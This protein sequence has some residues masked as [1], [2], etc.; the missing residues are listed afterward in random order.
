MEG[1][2]PPIV[3]R[4]AEHVECPVTRV[5][6][7]YPLHT[8]SPAA[9]SPA[10]GLFHLKMKC[11]NTAYFLRFAGFISI[12]CKNAGYFGG[13]LFSGKISCIFASYLPET[14]FFKKISCNFALQYR[15][16]MMSAHCRRLLRHRDGSHGIGSTVARTAQSFAELRRFD[17]CPYDMV[18]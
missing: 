4:A 14:P 18:V 2:T 11:K 8:R 5:M 1:R 9:R 10:F 16:R 12:W 6:P 3:V 15:L 17:A 13:F 7:E